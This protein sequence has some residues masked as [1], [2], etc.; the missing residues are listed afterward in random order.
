MLFL[1]NGWYCAKK[2][3][4]RCHPRYSF[5]CTGFAGGCTYVCIY[6]H[7]VK[8][9][10][11]H[12]V[13]FTQQTSVIHCKR[14]DGRITWEVT[15]VLDSYSWAVEAACS[16]QPSLS[17]WCPEM[18]FVLPTYLEWTQKKTS[19]HDQSEDICLSNGFWLIEKM[20]GNARCYLPPLLHFLSLNSH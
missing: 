2:G 8:E 19:W 15:L 20:W 5:M 12:S 1:L 11:Y 7:S 16:W 10:H 6:C 13:L 4:K 9:L 14:V 3:T 18:Q 17:N